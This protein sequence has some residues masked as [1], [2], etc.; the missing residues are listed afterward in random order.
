MAI[1]KILYMKD[2][3]NHFHGKHLKQSLDYVMNPEKTQNGRLIGGMNCQPDTAFRQMMDTKKAFGKGE[4][5][6][7]EM[8]LSYTEVDGLLYPNI[9][10]P[11]EQSVELQKLGKYGRMAMKYLEEMEPQRYKTLFRFGKLA[12]KMQEVEE[13]ANSLLEM[14]MEQYLAKHKPQNPSSTMEMWKLR[15]QAK[16]QAEEVVL[17]QIVMRFH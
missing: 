14:L 11:R 16:M 5:H 2:C 1:S 8:T 13:E 15:E 3:G 17:S 7:A 4:L 10:M 9:Q 6:M 12:E